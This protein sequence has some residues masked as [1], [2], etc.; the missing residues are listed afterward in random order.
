MRRAVLVLASVAFMAA[1]ATA[2]AAAA[3][4]K[5]IFLPDGYRPE[6]IAA[7]G[8]QLYVGSIPTGEVRRIDAKS[9][10][11]DPLVPARTDRSAIGLKIDNRKRLWVAGGPRGKAYVYDAR[12][13]KDLAVLELAPGADTFVNDVTVTKRAAYFTDSRRS[14]LYVVS[15][16]LKT[17]KEL[18]LPDIPLLEGFNLNGIAATPDGKTLI[19][20]QSNAGIL[21]RIDA[22]TGKATPIDLGG[23]DVA[24]GDGLL[25]V[26]RRTLYA[27]QNRLDRVAVIRLDE[28][29]AAGRVVE[30]LTAKH[31]DVP[32]TLA[33]IGSRL[34]LPNAR[35][36]TPPAADT[37]Y[38]ITQIKR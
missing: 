10:D 21:W 38:W 16:D 5:R 27:V 13:G 28:D 37:R 32:T 34:Y 25:L 29:L 7:K 23:R 24:N 11:V 4:P 14:V 18:P 26:G 33:R 22:A 17:V 15:R 9:G 20:V 8:K 1:V 2:I 35:F 30:Y 12:T 19:A 31:F 3:F 6:G 36:T